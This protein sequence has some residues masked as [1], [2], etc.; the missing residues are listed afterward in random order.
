MDSIGVGM[1]GSGFMGLTYSQCLKAHVEGAHLVSV[2]GGSR[3]EKLAADFEVTAEGSVEAMLARPDVDAVIVATPDQCR[4]ELTEKAAAAG[5]HVLVEKPM[6]PTVAE[7]D[8]MIRVCN[9]AGVNLGVVKTER[10]R[11]ITRKAKKL[12]DDGAIGPIWMMRTMSAF[13]ITLTR[14]V[15]AE[16]KWMYDPNSGGLFMGMASHNTDFLRWLTG[17]EVV[18]VFAQVNTFSDIEAPAQSV[19]AQLQFEDGLM[20]HMW[21]TSELPPPSI[22]SSEVRFEVVGRDAILDFENFDFLRMGKGESWEDVYIPEKFDW[23]NDP[24]NPVRLEP[25]FRVVQGFIDSVR[26]ERAPTIGGAEGR[27]AVQ[28]CE[29]CLKSAQTGQAVDLPL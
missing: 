28:I 2:T 12:I 1:I 3:A 4:L 8:E 10:F 11:T 9:Q 15:F 29:A 25:H 7:C 19:M 20:A 22:P 6:A 18:R 16:R 17:R 24:T 26:E 5:K 13:P 14:D 21:I 27:A 23:A